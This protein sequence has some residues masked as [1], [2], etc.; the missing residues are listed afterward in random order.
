VAKAKAQDAAAPEPVRD[1]FI[2]GV[3]G[4]MTAEE[5]ADWWAAHPPEAASDDVP[6]ADAEDDPAGGDVADAELPA[7]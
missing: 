3:A 4:L 5:A 7:E 2:T 1:H 6:V